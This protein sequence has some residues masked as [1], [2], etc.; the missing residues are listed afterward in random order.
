MKLV[1]RLRE[2]SFTDFIYEK[3]IWSIKTFG[4]G[5][6]TLG[7]TKHI[8]KE[9]LEIEAAPDDRMEWIDVIMLGLDGYTRCGGKPE[10]LIHD[11]YAKLGI[12]QKRTYPFPASE[13]EPS[14][15]VR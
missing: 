7:I 3:T 8:R 14:E 4:N 5:K 1:D 15:H 10:K 11:L 12:N 2:P 13:D 9:L 6:R